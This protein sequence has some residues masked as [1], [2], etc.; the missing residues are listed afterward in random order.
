MIAYGKIWPLKTPTNDYKYED[1]VNT[2]DCVKYN[3]LID[4]SV[5]TLCV[6]PV[7]YLI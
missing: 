2:E 4:E 1:M 3:I 6:E 7:Y 5:P